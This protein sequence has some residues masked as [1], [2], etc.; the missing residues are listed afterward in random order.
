MGPAAARLALSCVLVLLA[1]APAA[2][3]QSKLVAAPAPSTPSAK[4]A[5]AAVDYSRE[6]LV[7]ER[8][9]K[10]V[11]MNADGTGDT[12][13]HVV[14]RLQSE[15]AARQFS[16]ISIA[17][18]SAYQTGSIEHMRV[19]KPDGTTVETPTKEA[20]DVT[21]DVTREAPVYSDV[22]ERQLP[23]RSLSSGD[24]MEYDLH[25]V[26]TRPE[27]K[28]MFWGAETLVTTGSVVLRQTVTLI[29]PKDKFVQVWSPKRKP[30]ITEAGGLRTWT[31]TSSQLKP[32]PKASADGTPA[33]EDTDDSDLD[34]DGRRIPAIA[35]TTFHNW[36]EV[37][38]WYRSLALSRAQPDDAVRARAEALTRDAKTPEEQ[39][40]A[41]YEFVSEH[42]RYI[43]LDFGIG[44]YQPH[45]AAEVLVNQYGD[46]KDKDTL[47]EAL[48]RARGFST[49]SVL[50]GAG[51][52]PLPDVPTPAIFN[53]A[54]TTVEVPGTGRVW[55]DA[56][57]ETAPY[58][59]LNAI[60]RDEQALVMP[61]TGDA[62]LQK[63]PANPPYPFVETATAE[64]TLG[65]D[66]VF[67]G[68]VK[69]EYRSDSEAGVRMMSRIAPA[70][71]D[72][73]AQ[74]FDTAL[75]LGGTATN[76]DLHPAPMS[77]PATIAWDYKQSDFGDWKTLRI[78]PLFPKLEVTTVD[79]EKAPKRDIDLG[80]PRTLVANT[81]VHLPEDMRADPPD[82]VHVKRPYATFDK[83]YRLKDGTL[84][85][86]RKVVILQHK[87][88]KAE[89][90]DYYDF[91]HS[92]G[93]QDGENYIALVRAPKVVPTV[94]TKAV[95]LA[96]GKD[97]K[98]EGVVNL[99]PGNLPKLANA[100][101]A[102]PA[103][104]SRSDAPAAGSGSDPST[105]PADPETLM[106]QAREAFGRGDLAAE[107]DLLA[108]VKQTAPDTPYVMSMLGYLAARSG[109]WQ[110]AVDDYKLELA[111]HPD[112]DDSIVQ[113][114]AWEYGQHK[115]YKDAVDLLKSYSSR[116]SGTL[117]RSLASTQMA[118]KDNEGAAKTLEAF[119]AS[120]PDDRTAEN[121]LANAYLALHR[122]TEAAAAAH[123]AMDGSDDPL[124]LNN[125][126]YLLSEVKLDL[127]FAEER[128]RH[129]IDVMETASAQLPIDEANNRAFFAASNLTA[130]WDTLG[131]ILFE[132]GKATDAEP[133]IKAAWLHRQDVAVAYHLGQIYE[134]EAKRDESLRVYELALA[135]DHASDAPDYEAVRTS[136]D[137]LR[138]A[139]AKSNIGNAVQALQDMRTYHLPKQPGIKGW[140][141]FRVQIGADGIH[142][143]QLVTGPDAM[144]P[145]TASL[146][147][148]KISS[149]LPPGS[150][151][152]LLRDGVLSCESSSQ[153][154][155]FVLM[156]HASV[157]N[158]IT[159]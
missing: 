11:R 131:W 121:M 59:L 3:A 83:T 36:A 126:S 47:L 38:A 46:C 14:L 92:I 79:K 139:G 35:W 6:A 56:T 119:T 113:L 120:H 55:L 15:Q 8:L 30:E 107:V 157:Q 95:A 37:G 91:T 49:A 23:V 13:T 25:V 112:A 60:I 124:V 50:I 2:H 63:T 78:L 74:Y 70:Q 141:T 105:P 148:L 93:M 48:L 7:F 69:L 65:N 1:A 81:I 145:M 102:S 155:I 33:A 115:Q 82:A 45:S 20:V 132:E 98:R 151:A 159:Q 156:P 140:G 9:E 135:T 21:P 103:T 94:E 29:A 77:Q 58:R 66:G 80:A 84:T 90:K 86:E 18:A 149:A 101:V 75:G 137:R 143:S 123:A 52:A 24:T 89:W 76:A 53:H 19:H 150:R 61:A 104:Q 134:S 147:K 22:K 125:N 4:A 17:Y 106:Q 44:H 12:N 57:Q 51:I 127:P 111:H 71:W 62:S 40:R 28:D 54:I 42:I 10:T 153:Q 138:K 43:A 26:T 146:D 117:T 5:A 39:V 41:L 31:W 129:S 110:E 87:L 128:S 68:H 158:E 133:Y 72:A 122:S 34:A 67:K 130:S 118:M 100:E 73:A 16:V 88:P 152:L 32:T 116:N 27:A 108:K 96:N 64:G 99:A 142:A 109:K 154:C 114:L 144:K 136:A 97:G 85:V